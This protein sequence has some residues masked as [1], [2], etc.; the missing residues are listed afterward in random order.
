MMMLMHKYHIN[1]IKK[2]HL[3]WVI[4]LWLNVISICQYSCTEEITGFNSQNPEVHVF[5]CIINPGNRLHVYFGNTINIFDKNEQPILPDV[6]VLTINNSG[7]DTL[8][9]IDNTEYS[10]NYIIQPG[11]QLKIEAKYSNGDMLSSSDSV[12]ERVRI[13]SANFKQSVY[14]SQYETTYGKAELTFLDPKNLRNFY[15]LIFLFDSIYINTFKIH[16]GFINIDIENDPYNPPSILF[17]DDFFNGSETSLEI[18]LASSQPPTII[19]R[20]CSEE[21]FL[22]KNSLYTHLDSQ[23]SNRDDLYNLFKGDPVQ[24]YSNIKG[25]LGIFASY[26]E[27]SMKCNLIENND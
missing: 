18:L 14:T 21:Y 16:N 7:T 15:E 19:L 5:N 17:N 10:G 11:D 4:I 12:P 6:V 8:N 27:H 9:Y 3:T 22:Y 24:L 20:N 26:T 1:H 13:V 23:N 25:G 2:F